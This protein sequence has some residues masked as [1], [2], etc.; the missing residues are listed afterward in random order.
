MK[1]A[2]SLI[3]VVRH[4]DGRQERLRVESTSARIGS[5]AHCE[6]RLPI[7]QAAGEH[8]VL[9]RHGDAVTAQARCTKPA[10]TIDGAPF[11]KAP[12]PSGSALV[13]ADTRIVVSI[14]E[15]A[16]G[17]S[18]GTKLRRWVAWVVAAVVTVAVAIGFGRVGLGADRTASVVAPTPPTLWSVAQTTCRS[19]SADEAGQ[20]AEQLVALAHAK[21]LRGAF[22]AADAVEA[23]SL[24]EEAAACFRRAGRQHRARRA[25]SRGAELR[26]AS[27]ERYRAR[28]LRLELALEARDWTAVD[29]EVQALSA[30]LGP[31]EGA[32]RRWLAAL[33]RRAGLHADEEE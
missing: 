30:M 12:L 16:R 17:Q 6:V 15:Q 19:E 3:V 7:D 2:A 32:Y 21:H 8:V 9:L 5:A 13:L 27:T 24:Y 22:A 18:A 10:P 28:Q 23:V 29:R 33:R 26:R 31:G 14:V 4:A 1:A 20:R 25:E 11:T